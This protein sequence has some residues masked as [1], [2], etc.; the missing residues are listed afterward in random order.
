V[1]G[2]LY[3][4]VS[5]ETNWRS[6]AEEVARLRGLPTRSVGYAE[7]RE[8]FGPFVATVVFSYNSR[9]RCPRTRQELGWSPSPDR[10]DIFAELA[11]PSFMALQGASDDRYHFIGADPTASTSSAPRR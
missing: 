2:A 10:L 11:H 4:A 5:G 8:L 3:H 9:T 6:L 1:S 7:A